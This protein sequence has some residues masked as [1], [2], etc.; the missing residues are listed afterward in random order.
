MATHTINGKIVTLK[1]FKAYLY[2]NKTK[3]KIT[4]KLEKDKVK[5]NTKYDLDLNEDGVVDAKD[6]SIMASEL[7]KVRWKKKKT[8]INK[9][10][11]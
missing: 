2:D 10:V 6:T 1:E 3:K 7:A 9:E 8:K 11:S 4:I 5:V